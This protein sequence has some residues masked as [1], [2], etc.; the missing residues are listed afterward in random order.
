[1]EKSLV[2]TIGEQWERYRKEAERREMNEKLLLKLSEV[3]M[4]V[5]RLVEE[6]K[7]G[8]KRTESI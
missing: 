5:A 6:L 1:M 4:L 2:Q 7:D 3:Q 8:N